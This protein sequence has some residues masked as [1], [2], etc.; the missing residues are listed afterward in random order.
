MATL[1]ESIENPILNG[2]YDPP[3]QY[4]EL[5]RSGPTGEILPGRRL[6]ESFIPVP[7][8]RKGKQGA[9][10]KFDFDATGE[11]REKNALINDVR[12]QVELWRARNYPGATA[13]SRKLMQ[14]WADPTRENRVL[15]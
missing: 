12:R 5:G 1:T 6:S 10:E 15:F 14:H 2:P 4:F 11:R 8:S 3:G 9:Q 13:M 7:V